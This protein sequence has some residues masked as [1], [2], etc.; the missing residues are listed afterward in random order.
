MTYLEKSAQVTS[1]SSI[2]VMALMGAPSDVEFISL[3]PKTADEQ[4]L[5]ELKTRW[6]GRGLRSIGVVGLVGIT[7]RYALKEPLEPEQVDTLAAAFLIH[8]NTLLMGE[9]HREHRV[10]QKEDAVDWL[11]RLYALPDT[12]P[13][14]F[15]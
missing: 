13:E 1:E 3:K 12:R 11:E 8:V 9:H 2:A 7:P 15:N 5:S 10:R 14:R 4:T 6:P